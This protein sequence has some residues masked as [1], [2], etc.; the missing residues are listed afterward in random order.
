MLTMKTFTI[1]HLIEKVLWL[2]LSSMAIF[3]LCY[4]TEASY[5]AINDF[6]TLLCT[7]ISHQSDDDDDTE[8]INGM[9]ARSGAKMKRINQ[10]VEVLSKITWG[11]FQMLS[12]FLLSLFLFSGGNN[13]LKNFH[14][15]KFLHIHLWV[16][17]YQHEFAAFCD[18]YVNYL[19]GDP[20]TI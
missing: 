17:W 1:F 14:S 8:N 20:L 9:Y 7:Y 13:S 11:I 18:L 6:S 19:F 3:T 10:R 15:K 16:F 4:T 2:L 5:K 12:I